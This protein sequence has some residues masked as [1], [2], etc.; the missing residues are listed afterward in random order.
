[1]KELFSDQQ[2]QNESI[3]EST[4][5]AFEQSELER[6]AEQAKQTAKEMQQLYDDFMSTS[7]EWTDADQTLR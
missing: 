7:L 5:W 3:E 2:E 6:I 4:E 1:M